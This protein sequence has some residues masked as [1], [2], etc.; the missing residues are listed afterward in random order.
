MNNATLARHFNNKHPKQDIF[1]CGRKL[2]GTNKQIAV[3][4]K[5]FVTPTC[6]II[7]K[8]LKERIK[9]SEDHDSNALLLQ[10]FVVDR[11]KYMRDINTAGCPEFWQFPFETIQA[12]YG[13]CEDMAILLATLMLAAGIPDFRVRVTTGLVTVDP[14]TAATGGHAYVTYL[15]EERTQWIPLDTCYLEDS[16][17]PMAKKKLLNEN[18]NYKNVLFS[19]NNKHC[20]AN[21]KFELVQRSEWENLVKDVQ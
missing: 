18:K 14:K 6:G 13:D 15:S 21:K 5:I 9:L 8:C 17:V 20:W 19:F 12:G 1:F 7:K 3:D 2:P 4:P 10:K 16:K 11:I